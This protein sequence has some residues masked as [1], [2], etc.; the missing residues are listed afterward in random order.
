MYKLWQRQIEAYQV[1]SKNVNSQKT[2]EKKKDYLTLAPNVF[3]LSK[4]DE[5]NI[6][7]MNFDPSW[8]RISQRF[9]SFE[10]QK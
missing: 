5:S 8:F 2:E 9:I 10:V 4:I 7:T 6:T 1:L 3:V